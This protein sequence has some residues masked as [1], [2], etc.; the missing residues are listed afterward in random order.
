[1][2]EFTA[3]R[4]VACYLSAADE[5]DPSLIIQRAWRAGKQV[6]APVVGERGTMEFRQLMPQ[7]ELRKNRYELWEPQSEVA[8]APQQLDLVITPVVAFDSRRHRIGM[9]SGYFDRCFEFLKH[10]RQWRRPKLIGVAF[11]CQRVE[12]IVPNPWDV[13]LYRLITERANQQHLSW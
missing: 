2:H 9:G 12:K 10:K 3:A 4:K 7:T 13:R 6:F 5:V 8:I 1:M 11:E